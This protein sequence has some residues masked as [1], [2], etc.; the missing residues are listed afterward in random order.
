M[1]VDP[2]AAMKVVALVA[3]WVEK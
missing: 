1:M 3:R 2:L